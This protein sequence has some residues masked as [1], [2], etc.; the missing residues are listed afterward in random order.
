MTSAS[1]RARATLALAH[2]EARLGMRALRSVFASIAL[3]ASW[4]RRRNGRGVRLP[5]LGAALAHDVPILGAATGRAQCARPCALQRP[6][7]GDGMILEECEPVRSGWG[8]GG[9]A[10]WVSMSLACAAW[11][12]THAPRWWRENQPGDPLRAP[13]RLAAIGRPALP[14]PDIA[15]PQHEFEA[16]VPW[17]RE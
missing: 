14:S 15:R 7:R 11:L 16:P 5:R 6:L 17:L 1:L 10:R 4:A 8:G 13:S 9:T 2:A 12:L 3:N